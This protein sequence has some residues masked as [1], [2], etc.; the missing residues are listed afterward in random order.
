V[1]PAAQEA[2]LKGRYNGQKGSAEEPRKAREYLGQAVRVDPQYAA[3]YAALAAYYSVST[4]LPAKEAIPKAKEYALKA[5]ELDDALAQAHT[6][7]AGI[8]FYGDWDWAGAENEYKRALALNPNDAETHRT[9]SLAA[10]SGSFRRSS[11]SGAHS[12]SI[13][14]PYHQCQRGL[15]ILLSGSMTALYQYQQALE[16]D[17]SS[18]GA[19]HL[20]VIAIV[21]GFV[22]SH[23][24]RNEP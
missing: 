19:Q 22:S 17:A 11:R 20:S 5:L 21:Q 7:L 3:S 15:D 18:D 23:L 24:N 16:L 2:Y 1:D 13:R 9:Y 14:F 6:A 10:G 12:N 4:D 8:K